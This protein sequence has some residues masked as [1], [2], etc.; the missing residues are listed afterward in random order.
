M[1]LLSHAPSY[2]LF[3]VALSLLDPRRWGRWLALA[4]L[5]AVSAS[6]VVNRRSDR[7]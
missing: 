4:V 6:W 5:T 1:L 2:V 7:G 3:V